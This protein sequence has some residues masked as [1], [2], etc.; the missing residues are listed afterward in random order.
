MNEDMIDSFSMVAGKRGDVV[1]FA[2]LAGIGRGD[3]GIGE[4]V[5]GEH[6]VVTSL[7]IGVEV[8]HPDDGDLL[9]EKWFPLLLTEGRHFH[10]AGGGVVEV[11][12]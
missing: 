7:L 12:A 5:T 1:V 8:S 4:T 3:I 9:L 6:G 11:G 10:L 2:V